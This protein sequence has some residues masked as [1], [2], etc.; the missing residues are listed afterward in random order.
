MCLL[1]ILIVQVFIKLNLK[2][3]THSMSVKR[4]SVRIRHMEHLNRSNSNVFKHCKEMNHQVEKLENPTEV[5]HVASDNMDLKF[6]EKFEIRKAVLSGAD[7]LSVQLDID[8][9]GNDLIN[10]CC[11]L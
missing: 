8:S 1:L 9:A 3:V 4:S 5:C 2:I 11:H 10:L 7:L 6:L